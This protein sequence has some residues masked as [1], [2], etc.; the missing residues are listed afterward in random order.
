[1][2]EGVK[3]DAGGLALVCGS[4][5]PR[6]VYCTRVPIMIRVPVHS[7]GSMFSRASDNK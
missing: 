5:V 4:T 1:G 2:V 7:S 6:S 3:G